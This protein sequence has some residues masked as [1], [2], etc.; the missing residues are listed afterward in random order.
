MGLI[1]GMEYLLLK[2]LLDNLEPQNVQTESDFREDLVNQ[3]I[4]L[5]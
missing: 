2:M 1:S 5:M 3:P 4:L